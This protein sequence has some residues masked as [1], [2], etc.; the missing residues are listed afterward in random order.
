VLEVAERQV[1]EAAVLV[2]ADVVFATGALAVATLENLDV[3]IGLVGQGGLE[4]VA[5]VVGERQLRAWMRATH[6]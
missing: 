6:A 5:V 4:A 2:V 1:S 3:A